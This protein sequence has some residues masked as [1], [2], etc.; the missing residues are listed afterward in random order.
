MI[1]SG[2]PEDHFITMGVDI[3]SLTIEPVYCHI[4]YHSL[5]LFNPTIFLHLYH[6]QVIET[7]AQ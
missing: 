3:V 5:S 7:A 6:A 2:V 4:V 1:N